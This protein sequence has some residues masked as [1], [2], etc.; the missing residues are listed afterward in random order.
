MA[1]RD[2]RPR[3]GGALDRTAGTAD[4]SA[5]GTRRMT[6][7]P[8]GMASPQVPGQ[9]PDHT[10]LPGQSNRRVPRPR[11]VA[12]PLSEDGTSQG[13]MDVFAATPGEEQDPA[14]YEQATAA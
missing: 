13:I 8:G 14:R 3:P 1:E 2:P 5:Q 4:G 9:V 7:A 10:A 12:R 11:I 6:A